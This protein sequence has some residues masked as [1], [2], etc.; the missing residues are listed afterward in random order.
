MFLQY[1]LTKIPILTGEDSE[2]DRHSVSE[3]TSMIVSFL[4]NWQI[5]VAQPL[6]SSS[7]LASTEPCNAIR[8]QVFGTE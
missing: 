3:V 6:Q 1:I 2:N 7:P 8:T 4:K 5:G